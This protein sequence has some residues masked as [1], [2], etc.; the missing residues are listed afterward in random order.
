MVC[1]THPTQYYID[2][3]WLLSR[4]IP[5]VVYKIDCEFLE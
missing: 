3:L 2:W 1:N 5:D 4:I